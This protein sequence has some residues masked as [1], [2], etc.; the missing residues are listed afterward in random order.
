M[1]RKFKLRNGMTIE[2]APGIVGE[3][4]TIINGF[5]DDYKVLDTN[6]VGDWDIGEWICLLPTADG[7]PVGGQHGPDLDIVEEIESE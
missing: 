6:G 4:T 5:M 2:E 1:A 3:C 7:M